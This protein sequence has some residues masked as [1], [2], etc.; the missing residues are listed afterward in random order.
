[1]VMPKSICRHETACLSDDTPVIRKGAMAK[2]IQMS[3]VDFSAAE[4]GDRAAK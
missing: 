2:G 3:A 4:E 1:M